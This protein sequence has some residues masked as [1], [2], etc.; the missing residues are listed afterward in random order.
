[1]VSIDY[2]DLL[3]TLP[4]IQLCKQTSY[5]LMQIKRGQRLLE[6]GCATGEDVRALAAKVGKKGQ[7][8][9]LDSSAAMLAEAKRRTVDA[10]LPLE[11]CQGNAEAFDFED[12]SFDSCRAERLLHLLDHPLQ[13]MGEMARVVRPGGTVVVLEPDWATLVVH[14]AGPYLSRS[15]FDADPQ[16][17]MGRQLTSFFNQVGLEVNHIVPVTCVLTDFALANQVFHLKDQILAAEGS[18]LIPRAQAIEWLIDL[19]EHT[20]KGQ[21]FSAMTGFIVGGRKGE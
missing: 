12:G 1:M 5:E 3:R 18:G 11:F 10:S 15:I 14:P 21:F 16:G 17:T 9:G 6:V 4:E 13:A 2:L 8:V 19:A 20:E 7:V